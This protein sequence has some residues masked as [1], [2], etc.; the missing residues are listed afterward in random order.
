M[1]TLVCDPK[2]SQVKEEQEEK[3][4]QKQWIFSDYDLS[5]LQFALAT[6]INDLRGRNGNARHIEAVED[7]ASR[8]QAIR[9]ATGRVYY[10]NKDD[11]EGEPCEQLLVSLIEK[12]EDRWDDPYTV[13]P[14]RDR[15]AV[16]T[17]QTTVP[18][19]EKTYTQKTHA[20]RANRRLNAAAREARAEA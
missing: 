17:K 12:P 8:L 15:W 13:I 16:V 19:G 5:H 1:L 11:M 6:E 14:V 9:E 10:E 20:Y 18:V 3:M 2:W 7:L 4:T